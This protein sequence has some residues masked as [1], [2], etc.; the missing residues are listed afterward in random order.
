M[1]RKSTDG[2]PEVRACRHIQKH[3]HALADDTLQGP[4]RWYT[5]LHCSCCGQ[6]GT[7]LRS[8]QAAKQSSAVP[9]AADPL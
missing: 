5:R 2:A 4:M 9:D 7:T 8:L 3:V 1:D 6:C